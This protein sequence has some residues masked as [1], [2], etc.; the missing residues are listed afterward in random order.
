MNISPQLK[1]LICVALLAGLSASASAQSIL[2]HDEVRTE[3]SLSNTA[4][5]MTGRAE[6][7]LTGGGNPIPGC[8]IHLNSEDAWVFFHAVEPSAAKS[9]LLA[10]IRASGA[11]AVDG[12]NVRVVQHAQG[13]VV[14]PHGA[15]YRPLEV[16]TAQN[17]AGRSRKL[18]PHNRYG[19]SDLGV[20]AD[21][22]RSFT[23]KR[24]WM[25]TFAADENGSEDSRV[26][27]AQDS[28]LEVPV[29]SSS[30]DARISF[31]RVSPW[32]WVSKKGTCDTSPD[33]LHAQWH[34]NWNISLNSTPNWEYVAIKQQP[35]W[36]GT[37]QDWEARGVNHLSGF[38]EPDNP[39]EDAYQNLTPQG[40]PTNAA[41]RWPELL[42]T[43]LRVGAPA[44][45]DGGLGWLN[46]FMDAANAAGMRVDYVPVHYY[47][48]YWN[49]NDPQGAA[50][51]MFN[52]LQSVHNA[53]GLPVW[54]TEF[55]NGANWTDNAHDPSTAQN[56]D[57]VQAMIQMMDDTPWVER[58][59][60]YSRVEWFRQTHYDEGGITPM[61]AMY[62]DHDSPIGHQQTVPNS[63]KTGVASYLFNGDT[64]DTSGN[65]N[66]CLSYGT[67]RF[68]PGRRGQ[69]IEFDG[70]N[71]YL[72]LTGR[73]GDSSSFTF[74]AWVRWDG[75]GNWQRIFDF[76]DG[77][78]RYLFLTPKSGDNTLR[79]AIRNGGDEQRLDAP[80][81]IPGVW[82]HVA[83]T[84]TGDTGKLFVNGTRVA[85]NDSM[86][87]NPNQIG[88]EANFLGDSQFSADP[89]FDGALDDVRIFNYARSDSRIAAFAGSAAPAFAPDFASGEAT[90]NLT[91]SGNLADAVS[92]GT[93]SLQ[94]EKIDGPGWLAIAADGSFVGVPKLP[95]IGDNIVLVQVT[96]ANKVS[97]TVHWTV[98]VGAP[99]PFV[100]LSFEDDADCVLGNAAVS[101]VDGAGLISEPRGR[102]LRLDGSN[103]HAILPEGVA[104]G[105][106]ITVATWVRWDGGGAWQRIFDF[107]NSTDSYLMLTPRSS[108]NRLEFAIKNGGASQRI[109]AAQLPVGTWKHVAVRLGGGVGRLYVDGAPVATN[110]S[111]TITPSDIRPG[112]NYLG[113][114]QWPDLYLDGRL[115]EFHIFPR[116]LGQTE[117]ASLMNEGGP[118][119]SPDELTYAALDAG[120]VFETSV[121]RNVSTG[122]APLQ[123]EKI[124]GPA[125]LVVDADGRLS[126]IPSVADAG[127]NVFRIQ[128]TDAIGLSDALTVTIPVNPPTGLLA[129]Y[130]FSG[131]ATDRAGTRHGALHGSPAFTN[132]WFD[133]ALEFDGSNDYVQLPSGIVST[134]NDVTF[135]VRFRWDGGGN[136]QR[137]FDFG[138]NTSEYIFLTPRSGD[139]TLRFGITIDGGGG[140]QI[141]EVPRPRGGE[142][143]HVAVTLSGNT[144]RLYV[145]GVQSDS[146]TISLDPSD[147][148]P[149]RNFL[150]ESQWPDPHFD[151]SIDDFKIYSRALSA[152]EVQALAM[153]SD[154]T[155]VEPGYD[156]WAATVPFPPGQDAWDI[157]A[158]NDG[159][160]NAFEWLHGTDSLD[161]ASTFQ[162]TTAVLPASALGLLGANRY[163]TLQCRLRKV[164]PR[165]L[166]RAEGAGDLLGFTPFRAWLAS[167]ATDDGDFE[168]LTWYFPTPVSDV[169]HGFL[170][171]KATR[172]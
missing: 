85:T 154:P 138:N 35:H 129:H 64:R 44:V 57:A 8:T 71:D 65:G 88:T 121:I 172:E 97:S 105:D 99:D 43:G 17:F 156:A 145:N 150:G 51:Q 7:H 14:I 100:R 119:F 18:R 95:D 109:E 92:G 104:S 141:L 77:T 142:W 140:T 6:L 86:T 3:A 26:Y 53:T 137:V 102:V 101:L 171:L 152:A 170:R 16:F 52:F 168:I 149:T 42:A 36:P 125:W 83:V 163:L 75:G 11:T 132:G 115:D 103:D 160:P 159:S 40:S 90:V 20:L 112:T 55:N 67:P 157:D 134:L 54:V 76:G 79:F 12:A 147:V 29:L 56:R 167:P 165:T 37:N 106:E 135:A 66:V 68:V 136:W 10:R 89:L 155:I 96:D 74:A 33:D 108:S 39:V 153:P 107:G 4:V 62:R 169:E 110:A 61:G 164:R 21:A 162:I 144:G 13:S 122:V 58:Y 98:E 82:T 78:S 41:E 1:S 2:L 127:D 161:P 15:D 30:L 59:A 130:Q 91:F 38:N 73:F 25:V 19:N 34:Y 148:A 113:K 143:I 9:S 123:F 139:D 27:I 48:S 116:A 47:R 49:K 60:I 31:V 146:G 80:A 158:D 124:S 63:G 94:F 24:G 72:R 114:S 166:V 120:Q 87:I 32:R 22:I 23:L 133:D 131:D 45:T 84:I 70:E 50:N 151:G 117:I 93:G 28:D 69:A 46:D 81:L 111:I 126:G 118:E 128:V 5:T